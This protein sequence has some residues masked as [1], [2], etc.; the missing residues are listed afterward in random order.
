MR[1]VLVI[2][3]QEGMA[4]RIQSGRPTATPDAPEQIAALLLQARAEGLP[5]IHV[6][7]DDA[8]PASPFRKGQAGAEPMP[9]VE[10]RTGEAVLGSTAPRPST[11]PASTPI[12]RRKASPNWS[13]PGL[14]PPSASHRRSG[15][16]L[17]SATGFC[18]R[19]TRFLAL[20]CLPM[21]VAASTLPPYSASP[22]RFSGPTSRP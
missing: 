2:D 5:V 11:A 8:D 10:P 18:C 17:T 1:A 19:K 15:K 16:P 21:M 12:S 6:L 9:C 20:T 13:W 3:M 22:C 14:S 4:D 7:H